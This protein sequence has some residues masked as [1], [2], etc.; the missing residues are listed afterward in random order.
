[1]K[2]ILFAVRDDLDQFGRIFSAPSE[3]FA[4]R[5]FAAAV[6]NNDNAMSFSPKDFGLFKLGLYDTETGRVESEP[7]PVLVRRA[8]E[9]VDSE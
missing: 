6:N 3:A 4:I 2:T 1:M 9:V 7:V 5:D 8:L